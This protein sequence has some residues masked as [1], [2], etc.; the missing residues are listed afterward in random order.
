MHAWART[1]TCT[2]THTHAHSTDHNDVIQCI[3]VCFSFV[4]LGWAISRTATLPKNE[5]MADNVLYVFQNFT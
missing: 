3:K 1:S 2:Q 4:K 5:P